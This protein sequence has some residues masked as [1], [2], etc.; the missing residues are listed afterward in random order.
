LRLEGETLGVTVLVGVKEGV[1][2]DDGVGV[3]V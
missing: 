2:D 3:D 1:T